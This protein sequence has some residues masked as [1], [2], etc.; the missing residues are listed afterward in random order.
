MAS[1]FFLFFMI[2]AAYKKIYD[3]NF[4]KK[5]KKNFYQKHYKTISILLMI[6]LSSSLV[7]YMLDTSF[8]LYP[9]NKIIFLFFII[10]TILFLYNFQKQILN[11]SK[12][13]TTI[14]FY[15]FALKKNAYNFILVIVT[16][17]MSFLL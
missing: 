6:L 9:K 7:V 12:K 17:S 5:Y 10:L 14:E 2:L 8:D 15:N 11:F 3:F 4:S 16:L 1:S 13:Q